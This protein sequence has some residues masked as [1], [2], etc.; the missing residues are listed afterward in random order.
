MQFSIDMILMTLLVGAVTSLAIVST[1][2]LLLDWHLNVRWIGRMFRFVLFE[3]RP[4]LASAAAER[5]HDSTSQSLFLGLLLVAC[6]FGLGIA[7]EMAS[8]N[9]SDSRAEGWLRARLQIRSDSQIRVA[10]F[11]KV[12]GSEVENG[13][14]YE[15]LRRLYTDYLACQT[16]EDWKNGPCEIVNRRV[17]SAYYYAKNVVFSEESYFSELNDL[18]AR[19]DFTRA[20]AYSFFLLNASLGLGYLAALLAEG[21]TFLVKRSPAVARTWVGRWWKS[22]LRGGNGLASHVK[23]LSAT[24]LLILAFL[25]F[26]AGYLSLVAWERLE[27]AYDNRVFGYFLCDQCVDKERPPASTAGA[28]AIAGQVPDSV[29]RVFG[30]PDGHFEP[31]ALVSLGLVKGRNL[32]IVGSDKDSSNLYLFELR[33]D[34]T[35]AFQRHLALSR[36]GED[37]PLKIEAMSA[38]ADGSINALPSKIF[39]AARELGANDTTR[40]YQANLP[41]KLDGATS[42]VL[43][44]VAGSDRT[45]DAIIAE[46]NRSG[47]RQRSTSRRCEIEGLTYL[48]DGHLLLLGIR[49]VGQ[50][51]EHWRPLLGL[52]KLPLEAAD[53]Q[54]EIL[55]GAG[56]S[57]T[58]LLRCDKVSSGFGVSDLSLFTALDDN[59]SELLLL[60]SFEQSPACELIRSEEKGSGKKKEERRQVDEVQGALWR[61]P[62]RKLASSKTF[63]AWLDT[64]TPA[65]RLAHKP[66]GI[67][68]LAPETNTALIIFDDDASRKSVDRAP[69]TFPLR[70]SESV[71]TVLKLDPADGP[72]QTDAGRAGAK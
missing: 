27:E 26:G 58:N 34:G 61:V 50:V 44:P 3:K 46:R 33:D 25:S 14:P 29:Y 43:E 57:A 45:C 6:M 54:P 66:E 39:I 52:A 17:T 56:F 72:G 59:E 35:L 28:G 42:L 68:I 40:V 9:F 32:F 51:G 4:Y 1:L 20:M 53:P 10:S 2:F 38:T 7:T 60:S 49:S 5:E 71:F 55:Y 11:L 19:I 23:N 62:L 64:A 36:T 65:V 30:S 70:Q 13:R 21:G 41:R 22:K 63:K 48:K 18:Q 24:R 37:V 47:I 16:V 15:N 67:A 69:D 31:S 12:G 8:D